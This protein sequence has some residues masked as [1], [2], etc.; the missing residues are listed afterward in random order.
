M[1]V[2]VPSGQHA[3]RSVFGS[4]LLM[5][6]TS[7]RGSRSLI[8]RSATTGLRGGNQPVASTL[9]IGGMF[10]DGVFVRAQNRKPVIEIGGTHLERMG[11][12]PKLLPQE[13]G[14]ELGDDLFARVGRIAEPRITIR[15]VEPV[16]GLRGMGL[17]PMSA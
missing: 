2:R 5:G 13:A 6:H 16:P 14:G 4:F 10:E 17:M 7:T 3:T 8:G 15:P 12:E 9:R 11:R 1:I